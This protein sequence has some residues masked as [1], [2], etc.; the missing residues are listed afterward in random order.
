M[1]KVKK[2]K[3]NR[4]YH[5]IVGFFQKNKSTTALLDINDELNFLEQEYSKAINK[6]KEDPTE[7]TGYKIDEI[8]SNLLNF[9]EINSAK[10]CDDD[11]LSHEALL[12]AESICTYQEFIQ[13]HYNMMRDIY[14]DDDYSPS[15]MAYANMQ[16]LMDKF[17]E[18]EKI[19]EIKELNENNRIENHGFENKMKFDS[20]KL[21]LSIFSFVMVSIVLI[22]VYAFSDEI[23]M[24]LSVSLGLLAMMYITTLYIKKPEFNHYMMTRIV[25]CIISTYALTAIPGYMELEYELLGIKVRAIGMVGIFVLIYLVNPAKPKKMD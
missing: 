19:N 6:Y 9:I 22:L 16:R 4:V 1:K 5:Y 13:A 18:K 15:K 12:F 7:E 17:L 20:K 24:N 25:F 21:L 10:Y 3:K 14:H 23:P 8:G 2:V 11:F